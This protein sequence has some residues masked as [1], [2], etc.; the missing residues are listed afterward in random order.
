MLR[1]NLLSLVGLSALALCGACGGGQPA[2]P[3]PRTFEVETNLGVYF[4][5]T[6]GRARALKWL[7]VP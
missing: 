2:A 4:P 5:P 6:T 1:M 3:T 7:Q